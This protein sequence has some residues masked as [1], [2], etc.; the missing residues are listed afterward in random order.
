MFYVGQKVIRVTEPKG[1]ALGD[2]IYYPGYTFTKLGGIY[3]VR[4]IYLEKFSSEAGL[5][6]TLLLEELRNP[7]VRWKT[8]GLHEVGFAASN[9]RPVVERKTDISIFTTILD[10]VKSKE[11]V[12]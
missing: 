2:A 7:L 9:F 12:H 5:I 11:P 8:L 10:N 6:E 4:A 1:T 3:T